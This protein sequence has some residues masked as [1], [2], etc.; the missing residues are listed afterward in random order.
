MFIT[1][2]GIDG[3]GKTTLARSLCKYYVGS[4]Y[5]HFPV[6]RV[7][8]S[9]I[10]SPLTGNYAR[11]FLF[12]ADMSHALEELI[13]PGLRRG[14][15]IICD[16]YHDSTLAY[17]CYGYWME[18]EVTEKIWKIASHGLMPDITL[19][20][21]LSPEEGR[22]RVQA[23]NKELNQSLD[24]FEKEPRDFPKRVREGFLALQKK[25][26]ERI[27]ILDAEKSKEEIFNAAKCLI[28]DPKPKIN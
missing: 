14:C 22:R 8:R 12:L 18:L 15:T 26:S 13:I 3:A 19:L 20:L 11:F 5:Y 23:R 6:F 9:L 4:R 27:Y 24:V 21:D 28:E 10:Y 2:E 16:R 25:Y 17:Q 1:I 7:M